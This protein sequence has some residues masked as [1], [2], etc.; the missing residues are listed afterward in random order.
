MKIKY[1]YLYQ[2]DEDNSGQ[3]TEAPPVVG[4]VTSVESVIKVVRESGVNPMRRIADNQRNVTNIDAE[5]YQ[6]DKTSARQI[7]DSVY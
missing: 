6:N 5:I 7:A 2:E 1:Y 3:Q 4:A